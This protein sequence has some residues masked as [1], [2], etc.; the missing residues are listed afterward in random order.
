MAS[1]VS[2]PFQNNTDFGLG[3]DDHGVRNTLNIQPVIPISLSQG[4]NL[5]ARTILPVIYQDEDVLPGV[6]NELGLG[7]TFSA[8]FVPLTPMET[9]RW[10]RLPLVAHPNRVGTVP[11]RDR[12]V[13][14]ARRGRGG[15]REDRERF[16][17]AEELGPADRC[18]DE[19]VGKALEAGL[20]ELLP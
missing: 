2:V 1:L 15:S 12:P 9:S 8:A 17:F 3:P 16:R 7:D 10:G 11:G 4:W 19:C 6:G 18:R 20:V 5:I 14:A 13:L